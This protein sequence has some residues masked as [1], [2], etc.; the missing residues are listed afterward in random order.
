MTNCKIFCKSG[1][2]VRGLCCRC[3]DVTG[4]RRKPTVSNVDL[5]DGLVTTPAQPL[6]FFTTHPLMGRI[7]QMYI[8]GQQPG[9]IPMMPRNSAGMP[10]GNAAGM[11]AGFPEGQ[12]AGSSSAMMEMKMAMSVQQQQHS[13][14]A[15]MSG[16]TSPMMNPTQPVAPSPVSLHYAP[17]SYF[18]RFVLFLWFQFLNFRRR[19]Q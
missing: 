17:A 10:T 14:M 7:S 4:S 15:G 8:L 2:R 16:A 9:V 11:M 5:L 3:D 6:G 18:N 1:C 12:M 13:V 19:K